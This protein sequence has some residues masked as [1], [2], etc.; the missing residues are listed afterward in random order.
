M[1]YKILSLGKPS[2]EGERQNKIIQRRIRA[3]PRPAPCGGQSLPPAGRSADCPRPQ[4][5]ARPGRLE[6]IPARPVWRCRCELGQ[7]ACRRQGRDRRAAPLLAEG[8]QC[9][10]L[11][12]PPPDR[13]PFR[14]PMRGLRQREHRNAMS[15]P[16]QGRRRGDETHFKSG[17]PVFSQRLL[18]SSPTARSVIF[19]TCSVVFLIRNAIFLA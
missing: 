12:R 16:N 14:R 2:R 1:Y 19:L 8:H 11:S 6:N 5:V 15:L 17:L 9:P 13:S 10:A 7:L 4:R 18:T 3:I